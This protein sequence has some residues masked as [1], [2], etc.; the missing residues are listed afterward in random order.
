MGEQKIA[1]SRLRRETVSSL[2]ERYLRFGRRDG[3]FRAHRAALNCWLKFQGRFA[4][5]PAAYEGWLNEYLDFLATHRGLIGSTRDNYGARL[6]HYLAWQFKAAKPDW[7]KIQVEDIWRYAEHCTGSEKPL[8]TKGK[9]GTLRQ[10]L[11]FVH[12]RGA[13]SPQLAHAVQH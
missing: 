7:S 6:R 13:G 5:R 10:F 4:P 9:L 1:L 11:D 3:N 2:L 12:L 8:T